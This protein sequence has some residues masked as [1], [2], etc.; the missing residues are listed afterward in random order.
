MKNT[1]QLRDGDGEDGARLIIS[2]SSNE[3][4]DNKDQ[5][6]VNKVNTNAEYGEDDE[7]YSD[8]DQAD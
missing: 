3:I 7:E 4:A 5:Q 1:K 8:A 6:R 2:A